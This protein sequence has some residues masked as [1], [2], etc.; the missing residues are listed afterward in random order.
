MRNPDRHKKRNAK[1][2]HRHNHLLN[3]KNRNG[4]AIY[5]YEYIL[6]KLSEEFFLEP[7]T[8]EAIIKQ[9][10]QQPIIKPRRTSRKQ[11]AA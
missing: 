8:I 2:L 7:T 11:K 9:M 10:S 6:D 1:L 3:K 5:G 4:I